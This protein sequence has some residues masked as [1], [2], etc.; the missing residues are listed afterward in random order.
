MVISS[1]WAY[2]TAAGLLAVWVLGRAAVRFRRWWSEWRSEREAWLA[3]TG[4]AYAAEVEEARVRA[5]SA[6]VE[7][8]ARAVGRLS[9]VAALRPW[10]GP[11]S[12]RHH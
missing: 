7:R 4:P 12:D 5:A 1:L 8:E 2:G 9:D 3:E 11:A 10:H 6:T